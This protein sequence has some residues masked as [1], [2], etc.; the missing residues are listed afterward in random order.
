VRAG[1][2][3]SRVGAA[4]WVDKE[5]LETIDRVVGAGCVEIERGNAIG[6]V[7][8][9]DGIG[10]DCLITGSCVG[11]DRCVVKERLK[12]GGWVPG[13]SCVAKS[14]FKLMAAFS[15]PVV[16]EMSASSPMPYYC[17]L[18]SLPDTACAFGE[19]AK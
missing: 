13:A 17:C 7:F 15:T 14:A 2:T 11:A 16:L 12:T 4:G 18:G 8:H 1:N 5:R 3:I 10:N 19:S 6:R 9:P